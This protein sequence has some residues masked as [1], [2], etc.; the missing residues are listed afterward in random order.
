MKLC[1]VLMRCW[2]KERQITRARVPVGWALSARQ[3]A[4]TLPWTVGTAA[5]SPCGKGWV[6]GPPLP[7]WGSEGSA[8][9]FGRQ[10][11][12]KPAPGRS[13]RVTSSGLAE[14]AGHKGS[15]VGRRRLRARGRTKRPGLGSAP[16]RRG[17]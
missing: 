2:R 9:A 13:R 7:A 14:A 11:A 4:W 6:K 16:R 17:G 8:S 5:R 3:S 1:E 12:P 10:R 15:F